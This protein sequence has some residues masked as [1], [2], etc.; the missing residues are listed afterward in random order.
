MAESEV[1]R[2]PWP[3]CRCTHTDGCVA[4]WLER[5]QGVAA[6]PVCR[7]TLNFVLSQLPPPGARSATEITSLREHP[8]SDPTRKA[9]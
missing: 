6:C 5:E 8:F 4:G 9:G 1:F 3:G 2:C 7:P